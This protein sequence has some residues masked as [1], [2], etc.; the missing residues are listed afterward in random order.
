MSEKLLTN[1]SPTI[2]WI[3]LPFACALSPFIVSALIGLLLLVNF[4]ISPE[5]GVI[6][7]Y[8]GYIIREILQALCMGFVFARTTLY[9]APTHT[10]SAMR[11]TR[12]TGVLIVISAMSYIYFYDSLDIAT[13]ISFLLIL[14]GLFAKLNDEEEMIKSE[15]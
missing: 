5:D 13:I 7:Y 11:I 15:E 3:I 9:L 14:V 2:R 8:I 12:I 1:L 10:R 4:P 6:F